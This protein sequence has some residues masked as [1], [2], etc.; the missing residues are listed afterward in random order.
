M[1]LN[2]TVLIMVLAI[3][4]MHAIFG[5]FSGLINLFCT[6]V[7]VAVSLGFYAS[8]NDV[9]TDN[10]LGEYTAYSEPICLVMLFIFTLAALRTLA[11][12]YIRGNVKLPAAVDWIGASICGILNAQLFVGILVLGVTMLPLGGRVLGYSAWLRSE[13]EER[14]P[15]HPELIAYERNHLWTRSDEFTAGLFS[16]LSAGSMRGNVVF[17]S[18]YPDFPEAIFFSTNTVQVESS[19]APYRSERGQKRD[20][21]TQGLRVES[22]WEESGAIEG[23]YR[24]ILPTARQARPNYD[25]VAIKPA[26][27]KKWLVTQLYLD[28]S[29]A[30]RDNRASL[31]LFRPTMLRLVGQ[32]AGGVPQ[33]YVPR[34]LANTDTELQGAHRIVDPDTNTSLPG[35]GENRIYAYYEVDQDFTPHFVEY[36]RHARAAVSGAPAE[37]PQVV[38]TLAGESR[39]SGAGVGAGRTFGTILEMGSG[40]NVRLPYTFGRQT[41]QGAGDVR[42]EG[43]RYAAGRAFG[44]VVRLQAAEG[45]PIVEEFQVPSDR[46]LIQIRYKPRQAQSLVGQVF[47]YVGQLNQYYIVDNTAERYPLVGYYAVINRGRDQF[48]EIF[49]AGGDDDPQSAANRA[50]LDFRSIERNEINDQ[51]E[52]IICMIFLVPPNRTLVRVVNQSGEGAEINI[53]VGE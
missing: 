31:H 42:L 36:R 22:W 11:D 49:Y 41:L 9:L 2:L 18:I 24:A 27:G 30:D 1:A 7:A 45:Q 3:T 53:Q 38:L 29:S 47:N 20:G 51:E 48:I 13:Y 5:F 43:S 32:T 50:M 4:F 33:H 52:A 17:A 21:W 25:R 23:R 8:L 44:S 34:V 28:P 37:K 39:E 15:D 26:L 46:R 40:R 19:P 16:W 10:F 35:E 14:D 12:N 6:I